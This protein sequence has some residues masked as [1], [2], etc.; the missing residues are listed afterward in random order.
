MK[1]RSIRHLLLTSALVAGFACPHAQ[2]QS[3]SWDSNDDLEGAGDTPSGTWGI[4]PFWNTTGTGDGTVPTNAVTTL[5]ND[6]FFSAGTDAVNPY[7]V[8]VNG[9][10]NARSIAFQDGAPTLSGGS[11]HLAPGGGLTVNSTADVAGAVVTSDLTI[12]GRTTFAIGAGPPLRTLDLDGGTF[13][14]SPGAVLLVTSGGI[15]KSTMTNLSSN[16]HGIIAPWVTINTGAS[17][18]YATFSGSDVLALTGTS[19]ATAAGVTDLTG[20]FNYDVAAGGTLGA[21]ASVNTLRYTGAAASITPS[22]SFTLNGLLNVS[23]GALSVGGSVTIGS[24]SE[25]VINNPNLGGV[26]ISGSISNNGSNASSLTKTGSGPLTLSATNSYT[27][28]TFVVGSSGGIIAAAN[29]ALGSAAGTTTVYPF[30]AGGNSLGFSGGINYSTQETVFGSGPGSNTALAGSF[31][32]VQRGFVQSV[33]GNNTFAGA[34]RIM[35]GGNSRIGTQDGASLTLSGPITMAD[36][37]SGVTVVFRAGNTAGDF[38]TLSNS[39]NAWDGETRIFSG[40]ANTGAGVR[41]GIND[42]L[43]KAIPVGP[44]ASAASGTTLDLAGFHQEVNGLVGND[45]STTLKIV[46]NTAATTSVLT[47]NTTVDRVFNAGGLILSSAG[48]IQVV[49][50]GTANQSLSG[51]HTY[52]GGTWIKNGSITISGGNDRLPIAGSVTLGDSSTTGKLA[53]GVSG[54]PRNQTLAGL[55]TSGAG[56]Q[57]VG[58]DAN[59]D[60]VLT[61][62]IATS[63]TFDGVLGGAGTNENELAL[64]KEGTGILTLTGDH[65][66]S[67]NT[68]VN[69]GTLALADDASLR[70]VLGSLSGVNN[71]LSG[72]GS[73]TLNGDF[74]IDTT[75]A[76]ALESGSWTLEDVPSL[77][78]AYGATFTVV[79]FTDA[80]GNKW[81]KANGPAK[82]YVFDETTGILTLGPGGGFSSWQSANSTAGGLDDDHD[83]DGIA[84]GLEW[85]LGGNNNTTGFTTPLPGVVGNSVTWVRHPDY[86]G[87]YGTNFVVETSSTLTNPWTPV[88]QGVGAGFVEISGNNLIFTFPAGAKNFA[89]MKVTG[90]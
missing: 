89:R 87:T 13:T 36:G 9:T 68:T 55:T 23:S 59:T 50:T 14:R 61:L 7:T 43:P 86:P 10:Q 81:T 24:S 37:V 38:I 82:Q 26:V 28:N 83:G 60:S 15:L 65:T 46:N 41:L 1:P 45:G 66:Y 64:I 52:T 11:I 84:N 49:K 62:N 21:N 78:G 77:S 27:G 17:T 57:V 29:G 42:A 76:D 40:N 70:F 31:P 8:T 2:G 48:A 54:F 25:L 20:T 85:F 35:A 19:V 73:V 12:S 56:G 71:A 30:G 90:P 33:S 18:Q 80:G 4:D 53:L 72:A 88:P 32:A 47:L 39:G 58:A 75:A 51:A 63:N 67:G 16:T 6:L 44:L 69:N 79:G 5:S 22:G 3:L 74:V 34:I